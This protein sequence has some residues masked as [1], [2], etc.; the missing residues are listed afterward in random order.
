MRTGSPTTGH[1]ILWAITLALVVLCLPAPGRSQEVE[2]T[3]AQIWLDYHFHGGARERLRTSFDLGYRQ[4]VGEEALIGDWLRVHLRGGLAWQRKDWLALE[5]GAGAFYTHEKQDE[6]ADTTEIRPWQGVKLYWPSVRA[7]RRIVLTHFFRLEERIF[8]RE[9]ETDFGLRVRYRLGTS[10]PLNAPTIT[11]KTLYLPL[12]AEGFADF[13]GDLE[14]TFADRLRVT[15][16][17][18][19]IM[20]DNW[21]LELTYTAQRSRGTTGEEFKTT[22]HIV[23]FRVSTT[24]KIKDLVSTH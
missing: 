24:V 1:R 22:D 10:I 5:A 4:V 17:L 16:G 6:V 11:D 21:G 12:S 2:D 19:Y 8:V 15:A 3:D 14:E 9:G 23:R 13:G 20:D 18:G 7:P